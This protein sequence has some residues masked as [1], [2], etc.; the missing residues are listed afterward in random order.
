MSTE[1]KITFET[2]PLAELS[3][4]ELQW[5]ANITKSASA[6]RKQQA[7]YNAMSE[8]EKTEQRKKEWKKSAFGM[9]GLIS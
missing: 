2:S 3:F 5:L 4:E 8:D 7:E 6:Y 1:N 9:L